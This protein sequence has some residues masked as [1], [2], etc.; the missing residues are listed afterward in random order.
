[1]ACR[2]CSSLLH[3]LEQTHVLKTQS[4]YRVRRQSQSIIRVATTYLVSIETT[5][6]TALKKKLQFEVF[7]QRL[8]AAKTNQS[9]INLWMIAPGSPHRA[10]R[11]L[12]PALSA[13]TPPG[14]EPFYESCFDVPTTQSCSRCYLL[15]R[16][17]PKR[18]LSR[19]GDT[20][21]ITAITFLVYL[22]TSGICFFLFLSIWTIVSFLYRYTKIT[23]RSATLGMRIS[24]LNLVSHKTGLWTGS[25]RCF[26]RRAP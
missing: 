10:Q 8:R 1:M 9:L 5:L 16:R 3:D 12:M 21:A 20:L 17:K 11:P 15:Y 23:A 7:I 4:C 6:C 25:R 26:T 13:L 18:L 22:L 24:R 14:S 19:L 2:P